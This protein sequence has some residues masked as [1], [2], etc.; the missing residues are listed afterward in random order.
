[1]GCSGE[2][3]N[4]KDKIML[5]KLERTKIQMEK[6]KYLSKLSKIE[7]HL[8]KP[9]QIPDYIDPKYAKKKNAFDFDEFHNNDKKIVFNNNNKNKKEKKQ[10]KI[11]KNHQ[12]ENKI[13][14]KENK[15]EL[16]KKKIK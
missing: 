1:M 7:G 12:K 4:I 10:L 11:K 3:E 5:F 2:R 8:I 13:D 6:E 15:G 14:K 16:E 9:S